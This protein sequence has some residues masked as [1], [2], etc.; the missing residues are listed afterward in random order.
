MITLLNQK[1]KRESN[2]SS[3]LLLVTAFFLFVFAGSSGVQAQ[4]TTIQNWT[5]LFNGTSTVTQNITY[6]VPAGTGSNRL[7][8]VAIASS[9]TAV[10]ARTIT[11]TYGGRNF[12]LASG[13]LTVN[14]IR[15]HTAIYYLNEADL[16]LASNS[17]LSFAIGGGTTRVTTVWAAVFDSVDQTTPITNSRNYN[18][19]T[20]A[21]NSFAFGTALTIN[22]NDQ[23][24]LVVSSLRSGNNSPRTINYATNFTNIDE[25][26]NTTTD[27]TRNG[28]AN[29]SIPTASANSTCATT[30]SGNALASMTGMSIRGC[31]AP[32]V[33]AGSVLSAICQGGTSA[34]LGGSVGGSATGGTWT[35]SAGGTFS[36]NATTLNATWTPPS[37]YAG[38]ATL[39]LTTS[40]GSCGVVQATKTQVVNPAPSNVTAASSISTI[41]PG[42]SFNL[43]SSATGNSATSVTLLNENFNSATNNWTP[44]NASIGGTPAN[45][46]WTLRPNGYGVCPTCQTSQTINSNDGSQFYLSDSDRQGT[47]GTTTTTLQSPSFS[48][49]GL[50][51]ANLSFWQF[52][53][54]YEQGIVETAK[55]Q[56]S[57]NGT[58]WTDLVTYSTSNQGLPNS[59]S[60][61]SLSLDS[62]L[63]QPTVY[64]RFRYDAAWDYYWAIDNVV[65]SGISSVPPAATFAWTSTPT[66]FTSS[67]QNPTGTST[68]SRTYTVTA[69]NSF[70]CTASATTGTVAIGATSTWSSANGGSW[71]NGTPI[72]TTTAVISHPYTSGVGAATDFNACS[73]TVNNNANVILSSG[74]SIVLSGALTVNTGSSFTLNNNAN[75]IQSGTTNANSGAIVVRRNSSALNRLDYTLWSSPVAGQGLYAFSTTT[76]PNRFYTYNTTTDLYSNSVGFSLTGLQYPSPLVAPNGINGTDTNNVSFATAKGYLIRTPWNHPTAPTVFAGQFTGVP[77]S[78]NIT[79]TMSTAGSGFNLVGNPYPS[80]ISMEAFVEDNATNITTSLYFWRET[81]NNTSNNAY[82]QWNDGIFQSNGQSQVVDPQNVIRT[83]QGFF[84]DATGAGTALVFNNNQRVDDSANQFFRQTTT[85]DVYWMNLTNSS[86]VFS[87]AVVSYKDYASNGVDRYDGKNVGSFDNSLTSLIDGQEFG[88]Q[89][90]S[91]FVDTDVV[92]LRL[93]VATAGN[94]TISIE[95]TQGLFNQGQAIYLNDKLSSTLHNFA[96]GSYTFTS[97][98]GTFDERFEVVYRDAALSVD[99]PTLTEKQVVIYKNQANDFV[100]NTGDF[101]MSAVKVFDVR[102]RLLVEKQGINATQTSITA[103]LSNE[104]LLVQIKTVDGSIVTKKVI[105]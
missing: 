88:I 44:N 67:L 40:G 35:S 101:E 82:C 7:L 10:G 104:V 29:R 81:N 3:R 48:T 36:P 55:V 70:G 1:V 78:G 60:Q 38:T 97:E 23:A 66:G 47:G 80:P 34:A 26:T 96:A 8:A 30:F 31:V 56:V 61:A 32:T 45:A 87:Q 16:D 83:G 62:Y 12:T 43:T 28:I 73:L 102:G 90:K 50:T 51:T 58:S 15:Q 103:G 65:V 71:N 54:Y 18:S 46:A 84:V 6:T 22:A 98:A 17:T 68:V 72:A 94:Y 105:R 25:R 11:L 52:Y 49:V 2:F 93:K 5:N 42:G 33:T 89:G 39:T 77:N 74:D 4:V 57:T 76:L 14:S 59:F 13:D 41:C 86:G 64:I 20:S 85:Q 91:S 24:V 100:I 92:P 95:Q 75:L 9:Q 27:G 19:G 37:N 21:T 69:T 99:V 63:N 53:R 79:Y